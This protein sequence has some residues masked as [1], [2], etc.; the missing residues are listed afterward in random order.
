MGAFGSLPKT[1]RKYLELLFIGAQ[2]IVSYHDDS[3]SP[4]Q[5]L[6]KSKGFRG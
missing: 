5:P 6:R 3:A 4:D 1:A 2:Q